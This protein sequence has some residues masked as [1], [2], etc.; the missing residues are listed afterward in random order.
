MELMKKIRTS[1]KEGTFN[2]FK[3]SFLE[4]YNNRD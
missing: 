3:E 2:N 4:K 1:I